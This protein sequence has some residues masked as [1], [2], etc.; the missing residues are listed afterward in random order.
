MSDYLQFLRHKAQAAETAHKEAQATLTFGNQLLGHLAGFYKDAHQTHHGME[1]SLQA[2]IQEI[3]VG[4]AYA[5]TAAVQAE[6]ELERS[7]AALLAE[8]KSVEDATGSTKEPS[9]G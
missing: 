2:A 3:T 5:L 6:A 8:T 9:N 4:L 7:N 1:T